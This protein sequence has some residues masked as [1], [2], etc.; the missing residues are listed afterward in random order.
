MLHD[1]SKLSSEGSI[2]KVVKHYGLKDPAVPLFVHG[3]RCVVRVDLDENRRHRNS[4]AAF[5]WKGIR[6]RGAPGAMSTP[7]P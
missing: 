6:W 2:Q 3:S 7:I 1:L 4:L 5:P